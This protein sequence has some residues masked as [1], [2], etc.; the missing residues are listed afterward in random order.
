MAHR[1]LGPELYSGTSGVGLFLARLH[2]ATGERLF[3][4]LARAALEQAAS[5]ADA[6]PAGSRGGFYSGGLGIAWSLVRT[7]LLIDAPQ[8][9][10]RGWALLRRLC[11]DEPADQGLDLTS[12]SA[13]AVLALL[14]L[15]RDTPSRS[16]EQALLLEAAR[17]HGLRLIERAKR[18]ERGWSWSDMPA[19]TQGLCGLSHGA[20]GIA[21]ALLA[22][23]R[24]TGE[25]AFLAASSE[26][27][28]YERSWF[29]GSEQNWPD[30]RSL[31]DPTLGDGKRLTYMS[32]WCHGAPGI[33]LARLA[34]HALTHDQQQLAE[35]HSA[36]R[37]TAAGLQLALTTGQGN[38]SLCHG[39][40][41]NAELLLDAG[42]AL[43]EAAHIELAQQVGRLGAARHG[44]TE[45]PWPCGVL[46]GGETPS[47][48]LGLAGIGHFYLRL[49]DA[50]LPSVLLVGNSA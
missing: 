23:H 48:M 35:V 33:G 32:A 47:L 25:A 28:R 50:R 27:M 16:P 10:E 31:Y 34:S 20:A 22:L 42:R 29:N 21:W 30:L 12:G 49:H 36:L 8:L 9:A 37:T 5:Q 14:D 44:H 1:A 18:S 46:G 43:G 3:A 41:G 13:G 19:Q 6:L 45:A 40:A 15:V 26:A 24:A 7:G 39:L 2:A 4:R 17:R 38:F 11:A